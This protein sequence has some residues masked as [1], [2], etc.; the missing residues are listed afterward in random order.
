MST[1]VSKLRAA[2]RQ[3]LGWQWRMMCSTLC[4]FRPSSVTHQLLWASWAWRN[5]FW[6]HVSEV[7]VFSIVADISRAESKFC[8]VCPLT[9]SNLL[10]FK[11]AGEKTVLGVALWKLRN[12]G[13]NQWSVGP[14]KSNDLL[15][16][17]CVEGTE[18]LVWHES[19]YI[20]EKVIEV[21]WTKQDVGT[22]MNCLLVG[23]HFL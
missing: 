7:S 1:S 5:S 2:E 16:P 23:S 3:S 8:L 18:K 13:K 10:R 22:Q 21:M 14:V 15:T 11:T 19:W 12:G 4:I 6:S 20:P 9:F 17:Y